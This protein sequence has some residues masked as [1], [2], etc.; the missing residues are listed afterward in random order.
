MARIRHSFLN[1]VIGHLTPI[2][3]FELAQYLPRIIRMAVACE[4]F[5]HLG[6]IIKS[7]I[8]L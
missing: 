5:E 1:A 4:D 7:L 2:K 6:K 8:A 3:Y